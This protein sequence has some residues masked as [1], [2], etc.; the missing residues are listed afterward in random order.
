MFLGFWFHLMVAT[1]LVL[2]A[3]FEPFCFTPD[4]F[5]VPGYS[6]SRFSPLKY[7]DKGQNKVGS[8]YAAICA[9]GTFVGDIIE[10]SGG[11]K[12]YNDDLGSE[13]DEYGIG[14]FKF[15]CVSTDTRLGGIGSGT[16]ERALP[17]TDIYSRMQKKKNKHCLYQNNQLF[18]FW[19]RPKFRYWCVCG[20]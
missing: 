16:V 12:R 6:Y 18:C 2:A 20:S 8:C 10:I 3:T 11:E 7:T 1:P 9:E 14:Q 17:P 19:G 15:N 5:G 13:V 4:T